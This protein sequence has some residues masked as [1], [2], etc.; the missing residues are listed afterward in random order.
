MEP[1]AVDFLRRKW[2][3]AFESVPGFLFR[4]A[5]SVA[6][7]LKVLNIKLVDEI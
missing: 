2:P 5:E 4:G 3:G 6:R 1:D 7:L